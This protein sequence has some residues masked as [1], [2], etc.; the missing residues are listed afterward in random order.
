MIGNKGRRASIHPQFCVLSRSLPL[1][2]RRWRTES[3][4]KLRTRIS[5]RFQKLALLRTDN[6]SSENGHPNRAVHQ[7]YALVAISHWPVVTIMLDRG[8]L[9]TRSAALLQRDLGLRPVMLAADSRQ[10]L[11]IALKMQI[12]ERLLPAV[13]IND[14]PLLSRTSGDEPV[15]TDDFGASPVSSAHRHIIDLSR[16]CFL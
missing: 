14:F 13:R 12:R 8:W 15:Q 6:H 11:S 4:R 3:G 2:L 10:H 5:G 1:P 9:T 7:W 16:I